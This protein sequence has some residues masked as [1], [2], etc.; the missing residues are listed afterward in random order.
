MSTVAIT[1]SNSPPGFRICV[2]IA[3]LIATQ[4]FTVQGA[5]AE[6]APPVEWNK[7]FGIDLRNKFEQV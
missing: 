3:P 2:L 1:G 5:A 4:F 7:T 6:E